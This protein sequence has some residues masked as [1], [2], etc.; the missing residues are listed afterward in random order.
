[1][2]SI[3]SN[4]SNSRRSNPQSL[5]EPIRQ[6]INQTRTILGRYVLS[7]AVILILVWAILVFWVF[8][9]VDYLPAWLG[10]SESPRWV[11]ACMLIGLVSGVLYLLYQHVWKRWLVRWSDH[12]IALL[13]E[14]KYPRFESSLVTTVQSAQPT[15]PMSS[16]FVHPSR[17]GL[18]ALSRDNATRMIADVKVEDLVLKK[19]LQIQLLALGACLVVSAV[20]LLLNPQWSFFWAKRFFALSNSLGPEAFRSG[21]KGLS[22]KYRPFR[23]RRRGDAI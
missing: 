7:Q 9:W 2:S 18:L 16:D 3:T 1:M 8:G 22:L 4:I 21:S 23:G 17:D 12:A 19:P 14:R 11:R 5:P 10:A 20:F 15:V 6:T 13:I